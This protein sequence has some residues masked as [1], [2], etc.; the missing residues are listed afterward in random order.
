MKYPAETYAKAFLEG[1]EDAGKKRERAL[2]KNFTSLLERNG[3]LAD[4]DK[5]YLEMEKLIAKKSGGR[6]ISMEVADKNGAGAKKLTNLFSKK[7]V[8]K[9]SVLPE[10]LTKAK[11]FIVGVD[12][13]MISPSVMPKDLFEK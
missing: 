7:D 12:G 6:F 3:D 9:V 11:K 5:I 4:H 13:R 8:V 2:V 1:L 10:L